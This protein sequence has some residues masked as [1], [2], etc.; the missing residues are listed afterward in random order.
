M[1]NRSRRANRIERPVLLPTQVHTAH[2]V[3]LGADA[4]ETLQAT[5]GL[6]TALAGQGR[7]TEAIELCRHVA[8]T[9][10]KAVGARNPAT[11]RTRMNL[12]TLLADQPA[13]PQELEEADK[14]I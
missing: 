14:V 5:A 1:L 12:A 9:Q 10:T 11:L 3:T 8:Q 7:R 6:V 4:P 2:V 13:E